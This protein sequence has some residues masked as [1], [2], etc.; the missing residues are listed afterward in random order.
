[1]YVVHACTLQSLLTAA[2][3]CLADTLLCP[4]GAAAPYAGPAAPYTKAV[5]QKVCIVPNYK[6][7]GGLFLI[8]DL[9]NIASTTLSMIA[10]D[11]FIM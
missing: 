6:L 3:W 1:M 7:G 9:V 11:I 10:K 2:R 5:L 4:S 8:N